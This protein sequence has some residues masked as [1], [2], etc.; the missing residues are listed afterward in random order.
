MVPCNTLDEFVTTSAVKLVDVCSCSDATERARSMLYVRTAET[1]VIVAAFDSAVIVSAVVNVPTTSCNE[2]AEPPLV[3]VVATIPCA[4]ET[5]PVT[6]SPATKLAP[7]V[8][9]VT[10]VNILIS[11]N[12]KLNCAMSL[13]EV[14]KIPEVSSPS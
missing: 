4:P 14:S 5:E 6:R 9:P 13:P 8:V 7:L 2:I 1:V 10:R 11:N 12:D 3:T